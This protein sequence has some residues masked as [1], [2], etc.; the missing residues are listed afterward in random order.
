[1]A[2]LDEKGLTYFWGKVKEVF[3]KK[4]DVLSYSG[5]NSSSNLTDKIAGASALKDV[6]TPKL[7]WSNAVPSAEFESQTITLS[8]NYDA[9]LVVYKTWSSENNMSIRMVFNNN[10]PAELLSA[11]VRIAYRRCRLNGNALFFEKGKHVLDYGSDRV[12]NGLIVPTHVYG[13]SLKRG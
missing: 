13:L 1:M 5:I 12:H 8:G 11:D 6:F 9:I 7:I 4:S 2:F 10:T 3:C